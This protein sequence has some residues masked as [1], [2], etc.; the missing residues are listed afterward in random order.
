MSR[1]DGDRRSLL[2]HCVRI[3]EFRRRPGFSA[4]RDLFN[5]HNWDK[6][7]V[8]AEE[9][10]AADPNMGDAEI[11]LGLI[12]TVQS[13][14]GEAEK[15]FLRGVALEP[16]NYPAHTYLGSSYLQEKKIDATACCSLSLP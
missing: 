5:Q 6:A 16:E 3:S 13:R 1:G 4:A 10:L 8:A 11:L 14:F 2:R 7:A 12:A 15:H 9:A